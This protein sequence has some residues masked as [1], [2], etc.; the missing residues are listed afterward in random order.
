MTFLFD[1]G[2]VLLDFDFE[3]SLTRLFP[4]GTADAPLRLGRLLERK[5]EFETGRI[6][7][8]TYVTWA[9]EVLDTDATAAEFHHAWQQ[10]FTPNEPMWRCVRTLAAD[11]HRLILFSNING[12]HWPWVGQEFP[13]F[14]LFH[15]AVVSFQTGHIKPEPEIYQHAIHHHGL[16]P[17]ETLYIDDLPQNIA[18]GRDLGFQCWQYDLNDHAA[19]ESWLASKI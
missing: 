12:I 15:D 9:L 11:G 5:D 6:D 7:V 13:E 19:F 14:A 8:E 17:A 1:I 10:I 2:R 18:T 16:I 3:R 4:A